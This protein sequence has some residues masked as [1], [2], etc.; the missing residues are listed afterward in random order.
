MPAR[1]G[2]HCVAGLGRA[3]LLVAVALV[4]A[5]M[6]PFDAIELIR[7][8]RKGALNVIQANYI[9]HDYKPPQE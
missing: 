3:P 4:N 2:V 9:I 5:G 8:S 1:I 6:E 7:K